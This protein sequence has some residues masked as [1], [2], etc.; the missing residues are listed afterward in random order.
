MKRS[1]LALLVAVVAFGV[2]ALAQESGVRNTATPSLF[3]RFDVNSKWAQLP[4][5]QSWGEGGTVGVA[6]DGKGQ[7]I[8]LVRAAPY[9]RVFTTDGK[10]VAAWGEPGQFDHAH[11]V[12]FGS[13]GS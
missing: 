4:A 12:H 5:G 8:V 2:S 1:R 11:S 7:V 10:P 3:D 9:F 6:A 13:D